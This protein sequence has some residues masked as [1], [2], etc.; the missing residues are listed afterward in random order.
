MKIVNLELLL[1]ED[2]PEGERVLWYGRPDFISLARHAFRGDLVAI[3]FG[4]MACWHFASGINEAGLAAG[5]LDAARTLAVGMIAVSLIAFLGWLSARTTL[6]VITSKRLVLKVG[7]AL[8]VF[9]NIP[10]TQIANA[11]LRTYRDESGDITFALTAGQ[12]IAYL[13]L[14]PHARPFRFAKP[15]P[16]MRCVADGVRIARI[17]ADALADAV[18]GEKT[19]PA[20]THPENFIPADNGLRAPAGVLTAA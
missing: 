8:P 12:R 14:W 16:A 15:E 1:P 13:H 4:V 10:F 18:P 7:M 2:I 6:Y 9:F 20:A 19:A 11:S 3:Y 5:A 17:V